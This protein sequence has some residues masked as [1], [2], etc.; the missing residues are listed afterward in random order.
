MVPSGAVFAWKKFLSSWIFMKWNLSVLSI[1]A[2]LNPFVSDDSL[3]SSMMESS[4][5][6]SSEISWSLPSV[7]FSVNRC[8]T[9][10]LASV[11]A[12][13]SS[14]SSGVELGGCLACV[15]F[16]LL[17][18]RAFDSAIDSGVSRRPEDSIRNVSGHLNFD[19]LPCL[20]LQQR[21]LLADGKHR[22]M[23]EQVYFKSD[24]TLRNQIFV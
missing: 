17:A 8:S 5:S 22:S 1:I 11:S 9:S 20:L 16:C 24:C 19:L 23:A 7:S 12:I 3:V 15:A 4:K 6:S 21:A 2:Y 14:S 13:S 10:A 18:S